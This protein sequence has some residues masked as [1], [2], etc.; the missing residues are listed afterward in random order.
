MRRAYQTLVGTDAS[1]EVDPMS[2]FIYVPHVTEIDRFLATTG[3]QDI[4]DHLGRSST[5]HL[6]HCGAEESRQETS[7]SYPARLVDIAPTLELT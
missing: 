6:S 2:R 1:A 7:S 4:L 5:S 3:G